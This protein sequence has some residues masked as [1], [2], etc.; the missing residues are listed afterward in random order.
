MK[1]SSLFL[2]AA[3]ALF[4]LIWS[5]GWIGAR[6][7]APYCD[8]LTFLTYRYALAVLALLLFSVAVRAKWPATLRDA[9]HALFSGV[10][11]HAVYLGAVWW[12]ISHGVPTGVSGVIAGVQPILTAL[13]APSFAGESISRNQWLGIVLGF[14]GIGLVLEPK[15][16]GVD[17]SALQ[18]IILPL[19]VNVI[20]MIGVTFGTFYQ[21]RFV[22]TGDLRT[23]TL[24]QYVGAG[25]VTAPVAA[26]LEPMHMEWNWTV[27]VTMAWAVLGLSIGAI[28]LWLVMI[29]RGAV[30]RAAALVYLVPPTVAIEAMLLFGETLDSIQVIGMLVT[31]LGVA[32]AVRRSAPVKA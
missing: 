19:I 27:I 10:L 24:L 14:I 3:P 29:R 21:K 12:A 7:A 16:A 13:L 9:A 2:R 15:L 11:L 28:S 20:G 1:D 30:S 4:V 6:A 25:L 22:P 31:A 17:A 23:T 26:V 18:A 5:T 8:P 32:L